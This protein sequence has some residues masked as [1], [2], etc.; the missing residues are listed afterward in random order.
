M[1]LSL[2]W[3]VGGSIASTFGGLIAALILYIS[4]GSS[5]LKPWQF[6]FL[7]EGIP[8]FIVFVLVLYRVPNSPVQCKSFLKADQYAFLLD[9]TA[10][11]QER[12]KR[13]STELAG[14]DL[15][16]LTILRDKRVLLLSAVLFCWDVGYWGIVFWLPQV[17]RDP[18]NG[19][20]ERSAVTVALL[21][22]IPNALATVAGIV[23]AWN[24]D[25][26]RERVWHGVAGDLIAAFGLGGT[27]IF[28]ATNMNP[29][30]S[31]ALQVI[32]LTISKIGSSIFFSPFVAFQGDLL[33]KVRSTDTPRVIR[34]EWWES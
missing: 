3:L 26:T 32:F 12:K 31:S 15:S 34:T 2:G 24:S 20:E 18:G 25:R 7:L 27:A 30:A 4:R 19:G 14:D 17:L 1:A 5:A 8:C 29:T 23:A 33:P 13:L 21:S 28:M 16:F 11:E 9:A 22:V 10:K 6:L